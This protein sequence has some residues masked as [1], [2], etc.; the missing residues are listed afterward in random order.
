MSFI[1]SLVI[2][3][4]LDA[5][6]ACPF[7]EGRI[8]TTPKVTDMRH[9]FTKADIFNSDIYDEDHRQLAASFL[10]GFNLMEI[11]GGPIKVIA[12]VN[13][14]GSVV[15]LEDM[16]ARRERISQYFFLHILVEAINKLSIMSRTRINNLTLTA[17]RVKNLPDYFRIYVEDIDALSTAITTAQNALHEDAPYRF[18]FSFF[19]FGQQQHISPPVNLRSTGL[20]SILNKPHKLQSCSIHI[21][22]TY[23]HTSTRFSTFW[24]L[25]KPTGYYIGKDVKKYPPFGLF[26]VGNVTVKNPTHTGLLSNAWH[27]QVRQNIRLTYSQFYTPLNKSFSSKPF[28]DHPFLLTLLLGKEYVQ[29]TPAFRSFFNSTERDSDYLSLKE[30]ILLHLGRAHSRCEFVFTSQN[31]RELL[32]VDLNRLAGSIK[33][34]SLLIQVSFTDEMT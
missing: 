3:R 34:A 28:Q 16:A 20:S 8:F 13:K 11:G 9:Y 2:I 7:G 33:S 29:H 31:I 27:P 21:A 15:E 18:Y 6:N 23:T 24:N 12:V 10:P 30:F 32:S 5:F 14:T 25:R 1:H 17:S 22:T 4:S 26:E 19:K